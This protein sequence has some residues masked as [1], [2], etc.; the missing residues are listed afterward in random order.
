MIH[1][2]CNG[3]CSFYRWRK[4]KPVKRPSTSPSAADVTSICSRSQQES[5]II[6]GRHL[7]GDR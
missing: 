4:A 1:L 2:L 3:K 6:K 7:S 5:D